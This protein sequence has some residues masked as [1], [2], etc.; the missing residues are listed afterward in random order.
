[1][2]AVEAAFQY[3]AVYLLTGSVPTAN[4]WADDIAMNESAGKSFTD[5][6]TTSFSK[7]KIDVESNM[8]FRA[9][10]EAERKVKNLLL[11]NADDES[12]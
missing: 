10:A 4:D 2:A 6:L 12:Q 1:M 9:M 8:L 3:G 11:E 5:F 7:A